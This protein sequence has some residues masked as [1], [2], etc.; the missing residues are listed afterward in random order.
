MNLY[1]IFQDVVPHAVYR[2]L[3][4]DG[5]SSVQESG[6]LQGINRRVIAIT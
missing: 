4:A 3:T 1:L 6:S 2:G 5:S